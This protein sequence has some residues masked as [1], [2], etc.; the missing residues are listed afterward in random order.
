MLEL[1]APE[2][3]FRLRDTWTIRTSDRRAVSTAAGPRYAV[4]A[5][6]HRHGREGRVR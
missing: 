2:T 6:A 4:R 3:D 1:F 5:E